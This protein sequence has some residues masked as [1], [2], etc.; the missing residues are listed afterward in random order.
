MIL[1]A[2]NTPNDSALLWRD[3]NRAVLKSFVVLSRAWT[4]PDP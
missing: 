2:S 4:V 1:I 3:L